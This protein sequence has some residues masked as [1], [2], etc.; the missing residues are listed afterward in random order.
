MAACSADQSIDARKIEAA[1]HWLDQLPGHRRDHRVQMHLLEPG[2][3]GLELRE[4]GGR[5]IRQLA[6][7]DQE[8]L[9]VDDELRPATLPFQRGG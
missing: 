6:A 2:P 4:A 9:A 8:R 7:E 3:R 5:G 1:L